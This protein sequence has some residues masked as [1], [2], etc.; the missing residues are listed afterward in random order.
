MT[1]NWIFL[2]KHETQTQH[3]V[4][5]PPHHLLHRVRII[6][7]PQPHAPPLLSS[8]HPLPVLSRRQTLLASLLAHPHPRVSIVLNPPNCPHD[9]HCL[10][11]QHHQTL[12]N[13]NP[14]QRRFQLRPHCQQALKCVIC[15]ILP[16]S[17]IRQTRQLVSQQTLFQ[18]ALLN[19]LR[20]PLNQTH[21]VF[22][23]CLLGLFPYQSHY[24]LFIASLTSRRS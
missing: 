2:I 21:A 11:P 7:R 14:R 16:H 18:H 12:L 3:P 23:L 24:A 4:K 20:R 6:P 1:R 10:P 19:I 8:L 17:P 5:S 9:R 13:P 15:N 22:H